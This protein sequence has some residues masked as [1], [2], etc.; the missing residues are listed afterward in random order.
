MSEINW[1]ETYPEPFKR[2]ETAGI[3]AVAA[4]GFDETGISDTKELQK[5]I[6]KALSMSLQAREDT[7]EAGEEYGESD[8]GA[9]CT[10]GM[11]SFEGIMQFCVQPLQE[12]KA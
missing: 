4:C 5:V 9:A 8:S 6:E 10:Y 11:G 2:G 7:I 3:A 12:V 1:R